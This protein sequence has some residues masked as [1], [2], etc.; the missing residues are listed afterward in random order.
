M[1]DRRTVLTLEQLIALCDELRALI[2]A[3]VPFGSSLRTLSIEL[4]RQ[5][6]AVATRIGQQEEAGVPL[7]QAIA[8]PGLRLPKPL[9]AAV[10]AGVRSNRLAEVLENFVDTTRRAA[11]MRRTILLALLYPLLV[12]IL[13]CT[14]TSLL[15]ARLSDAIQET[16]ALQIG[17]DSPLIPL[18]QSVE[19]I[20][21]W[22]WVGMP[23]TLLAYAIWWSRSRY[24]LTLAAPGG[25]ETEKWIPWIGRMLQH[26]RRA[27]FQDVLATM[28][29]S[30]V[31][32]PDALELAADAAG[33]PAMQQ[34][35]RQL[36]ARLRA[37]HPRNVDPPTHQLGSADV[38]QPI[39]RQAQP[40]SRRALP[41]I[42]RWILMRDQSTEQLVANLREQANAQREQAN[43]VAA[44]VRVQLP[45]TLTLLLGGS[46]TLA[47]A[48]LVVRPWAAMLAEMATQ[49]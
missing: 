44:W 24:A 18:S 15:L 2:R 10:Q 26:S 49:R 11:E 33:G 48:L 22:A 13:A 37:G 21:H 9:I 45:S 4:P 31:P 14:L 7:E 36:A 20:A 25:A 28:I 34:E 19:Q 47:Y 16:V 42:V 29:D 43:D 23:I 46:A 40:G 17:R 38:G 12:V 39:L 41:A 30:G 27:T 35:A 8:S 1:P 32:L 3:G 6:R 5:L